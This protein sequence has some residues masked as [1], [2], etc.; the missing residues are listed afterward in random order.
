V[1]HNFY[2]YILSNSRRSV[3]YIGYTNNLK[4]RLLEHIDKSVNTHSFAKKYNCD[5]IVYYEHHGY[6]INA[7][8]REKQLKRWSRIKKK[9]LILLK[10][11][12]LVSYNLQVLMSE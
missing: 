4:R 11:P 7:L 6:I 5:D 10:N 9:K 12:G 1:E 3:F 2:V 8:A